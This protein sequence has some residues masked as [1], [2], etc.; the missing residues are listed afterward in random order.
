MAHTLF[1]DHCFDKNLL[2][3]H[4][5][6]QTNLT[7]LLT[8]ATNIWFTTSLTMKKWTLKVLNYWSLFKYYC[9]VI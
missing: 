8:K 4:Q 7:R 9:S 1:H 6:L 2:F 3:E 5:R